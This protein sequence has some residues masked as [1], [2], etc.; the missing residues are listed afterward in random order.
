MPRAKSA[1]L[2]RLAVLV[3]AVCVAVVG[4]IVESARY[5]P[6]LSLVSGGS[7]LDEAHPG[8]A[9]VIVG[10]TYLNV[11]PAALPIRLRS[12]TLV[13]SQGLTLQGALIYRVRVP[14]TLDPGA[15]GITLY[16]VTRWPGCLLRHDCL[17]TPMIVDPGSLASAMGAPLV[18]TTPATP[19][20]VA[21]VITTTTLQ[22]G[23]ARG[24]RFD[25]STRLG[26][27]V[28]VQ[29]TVIALGSRNW[30][31]VPLPGVTPILAE[32]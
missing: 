11:H 10:V 25:F 18:A 32:G 17:P 3:V 31:S 7:V 13:D 28:L 1:H 4:G 21:V 16:P 6:P 23:I 30:L 24:E 27:I 19:Y 26:D 12:V 22:G 9:G 20:Q 5:V 14:T 15:P 2:A 29:D 8:A